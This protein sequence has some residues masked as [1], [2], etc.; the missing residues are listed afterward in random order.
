MILLKK[1]VRL[2][3]LVTVKQ[4]KCVINTMLITIRRLVLNFVDVDIEKLIPV[5]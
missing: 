5:H 2:S 1:W 4:I 3:F